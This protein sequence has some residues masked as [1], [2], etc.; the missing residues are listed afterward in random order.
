MM[1]IMIIMLMIFKNVVDFADDVYP[2]PFIYINDNGNNSCFCFSYNF[3]LNNSIYCIIL[4]TTLLL[5]LQQLAGRDKNKFINIKQ[6]QQ[7]AA[8]KTSM[9]LSHTINLNTKHS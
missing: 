7:T 2:L 6:Q 8:I 1:M 9:N 3:F 4:A 5:Y